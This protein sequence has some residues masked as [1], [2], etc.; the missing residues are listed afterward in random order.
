[1][2]SKGKLNKE[3]TPQRVYALLKLIAYTNKKCTKEEIYKYIQ[4]E[5]LSETQSEVKKRLSFV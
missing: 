4:P 3:V 2:F 1:M 5:H